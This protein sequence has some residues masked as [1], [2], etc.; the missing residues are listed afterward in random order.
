MGLVD[1]WGRIVIATRAGVG[2]FRE[3]YLDADPNP[4][5]DRTAD[6]WSSWPARVARN[7]LNWAFYQND[8]YRQV[9]RI[10]RLY[11]AT[12]G[13]YRHVRGVYNPAARLIDFWSTHLLGGRLDREAGDG[14]EAASALPIEG[15][16]DPLRKAIA[17]LWRDG[18]FEERKAILTM[19][20]PLFGDPILRAVDD[21]EKGQVYLLPVHPSTVAWKDQDARGNVKAYSIEELR[22][23]PRQSPGESNR[24]WVRYQETAERGAGEDV[25]FNTYLDGVPYHWEGN[26]GPM[27]AVPYGFIPLF[28]AQHINAGLPWGVNELHTVRAKFDGVN[29]LGS[30]LHDFIRKEAEGAWLLAGVQDPGQAVAIPRTK[31]RLEDP[32]STSTKAEPER[33]AK[34]LIYGPVGAEAF[35]LVSD[36]DVA[37]VTAEIRAAL[38]NLEDDRPELRYERL[39][40]A[41]QI[42]G[43]ALR[44]ARQPVATRVKERRPAYD[45]LIMRAQ[46]AA[47]AIGGWR[48]Y[49]GYRGF[50]LDSYK[51]GALDHQIG[52][53][54]V[55]AVETLD[56]I[57][58]DTAEGQAVKAWVDA[59]VP[60][61]VA[62]RKAGWPEPDIA[63]VM[64]AKDAEA[65][66]VAKRQ[67]DLMSGAEQVPGMLQ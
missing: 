58:E 48:G 46:A 21:T 18:N 59:G 34:P 36:L 62:L 67:A 61:E 56:R 33:E 8:A 5:R 47:V 17:T 38:D 15:A 39:R 66:A 63:A 31:S 14:T 41:G 20:G 22:L 43:E 52:D 27:W 1:A 11:K 35:S 60:L 53:R 25:V 19:F 64:K 26:P 44:V 10:A 23:D 37:H 28:V 9:R 13:L 24:R 6:D 57:A 50:S 2:A 45:H 49:E 29:D 7:E 4:S 54:P 12:F 65:R 16:S 40:A 51:A 30:K 55:F 32:A 3:A 42:S